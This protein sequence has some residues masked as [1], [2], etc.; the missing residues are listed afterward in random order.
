LDLS[1]IVLHGTTY[2]RKARISAHSG[3]VYIFLRP[4]KR[5]VCWE[6][7]FDKFVDFLLRGICIFVRVMHKELGFPAVLRVKIAGKLLSA[8]F[9][10][11][12]TVVNR[13][14]SVYKD[15]SLNFRHTACRYFVC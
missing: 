1:L 15:V 4:K 10:S 12:L 7:I 13:F 11:W 14:A 3:V 8:C 5:H 9:L 6:R 2:V